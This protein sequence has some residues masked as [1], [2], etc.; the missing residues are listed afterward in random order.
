MRAER[1]DVIGTLGQAAKAVIEHAHGLVCQRR[2]WVLNEKKLV[3]QASIGQR[4]S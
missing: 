1:G 4:R 3:E 2:Q